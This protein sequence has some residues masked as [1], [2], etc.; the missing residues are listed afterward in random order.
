MAAAKVAWSVQAGRIQRNPRAEPRGLSRNSPSPS[1][2]NPSKLL[3]EKSRGTCRTRDVSRN[4][5]CRRAIASAC[6]SKRRTGA[7]LSSAICAH[8]S[9]GLLASLALIFWVCVPE[10]IQFTVPSRSIDSDLSAGRCRRETADLGSG[11]Q[12]CTQAVNEIRA[13]R[14][15]ASWESDILTGHYCCGFA[16]ARSKFHGMRVVLLQCG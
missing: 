2:L 3:N 15:R 12:V 1:G 9:T 16:R 11:P 14:W 5:H 8:S 7:T 13:V 10:L 4:A 6:T